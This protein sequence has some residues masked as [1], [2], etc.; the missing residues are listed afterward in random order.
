MCNLLI[1]K[2]S[3]DEACRRCSQVVHRGALHPF[4]AD[5][6]NSVHAV[7]DEMLEDGM[8]VLAR[9]SSGHAAS[10]DRE[11]RARSDLARLSGL[12]RCAQGQRCQR[13]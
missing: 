12:F 2:G 7:V 3:I 4:G 8:K 10:P 11:R 6:L 13:D 1:V 9:L 5:G